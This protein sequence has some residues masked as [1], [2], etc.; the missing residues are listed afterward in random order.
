MT[1]GLGKR[2][3]DLRR[4]KGMSQAELALAAHITPAYLSY[5]EQGKR[6]PRAA[7]IR[8]LAEQLG[9]TVE[10]LTTGRGG[11]GGGV[12]L[13]LR[14]AEL[15]LRSGDP[16]AARERFAAVY[17]EAAARGD[18]YAPEQYEAL[19]GLARADEALGHLGDA[20]RAFET[21]LL[22]RD[23]PSTVNRTS[24][25]IWLCRAY[26]HSG[27][28]NRAI[29][30]GEAVLA[31]V[32]APYGEF[33][34]DQITALTST[35]VLAYVERGDLTRAQLLIDSAVMAAEASGSMP[36]R[37]AAYWN[38]AV[39]AESRGESRVALRFA[40]RALALYGEI[41]D[42]WAAAHMKGNVAALTIR[43][44]GADLVA[45]ERQ[46]LQSLREM[47][48]AAASQADLAEMER[49]LARCYLLAGQ[50][51]EA[52][53]VASR[54]L[55]RVESGAPLELARVKAVLAAALLAAGAECE[56]VAAYEDAADT[57]TR[58]G[59]GRQ[60]APVW[61]E[62]AAVLKA[63]GRESHA[64]VALERMADAMGVPDVP[65]RPVASA[66]RV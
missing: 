28:L 27:D 57:L 65:V 43:L 24:L 54:A 21:L 41:G 15:A 10:Y 35:L 36:A 19:Y 3:H 12:E 50:V 56:A 29:E 11:E 6:R 30:L 26:T 23:L 45:A 33:V 17:R 18:V 16:A 4:G 2:V 8:A 55:G 37:A 58:A 66:R 42:A 34:S 60:A 53:E 48:D 63:M 7:V 14:F 51:D 39:V 20:I 49:E 5:V 38:A 59:A 25:R 9:T 22:A 47:A 64:I 46:L 31:D 61:R 44:P 32:A 1:D 13:D 40:E 62:L 52:V